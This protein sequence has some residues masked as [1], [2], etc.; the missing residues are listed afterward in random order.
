MFDLH[1][2]GPGFVPHPFRAVWRA[3]TRAAPPEVGFEV[4]RPAGVDAVVAAAVGDPVVTRCYLGRGP[5][6]AVEAQLARIERQA[7]QAGAVVV[8]SVHGIASAN[9]GG[10]PAVM[11]GVEGAD[12]LG[13]DVD[14][15]DAWYRRGVRLIGLVH[16]SDNR[17]GTTSLPWQHYTGRLPVRRRADV[18][19]SPIG[20][21][22]VER[23]NQLGMVVDIA[24]CD[25]P[26]VR[27]IA[28]LTTAPIVA[29]HTGARALQDFPRYLT[30][31]ELG[32]IA[33]TGGLVGLWP[34]WSRGAGVRDLAALMTHARYIA[35]TVGCEHIGVGTDMNGIPAAMAGF[36]GEPD[37][38]NLATAL[39][40]AGFDD[41]EVSGILGGNAVRV[42]TQV[43]HRSLCADTE[44]DSTTPGHDS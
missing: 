36:G 32:A 35:D 8:R 43:E 39:V 41:R 12:A 40:K 29:S 14:L 6:A 13:G 2:H 26:T 4:L 37:L 9:A 17:L 31:S 11:L 38:P 23:M 33:A 7:A 18:G 19:L 28:D 27:D 25:Q 24:H 10:T 3:A 5:L 21:R 20:A 16:L 1:T 15:V 42:L 44:D 30:D 34:Y 22:V